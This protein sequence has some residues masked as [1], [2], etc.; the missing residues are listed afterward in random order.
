MLFI[1]Y[2]HVILPAHL[3]SKLTKGKLLTEREWRD[4]GVQQS[5]GWEHYAVHK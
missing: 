3:A 1:F 2:R 5:L 4:L